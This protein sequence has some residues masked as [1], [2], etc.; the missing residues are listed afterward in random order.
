MNLRVE[1]FGSETLRLISVGGQMSKILGLAAEQ[2]GGKRAG[3]LSRQ[4]APVPTRRQITS[5]PASR[6]VSTADYFS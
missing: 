2:S 6:F 5:I 3:F 1:R 4:F